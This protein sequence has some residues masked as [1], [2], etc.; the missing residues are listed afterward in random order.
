MSRSIYRSRRGEAAIRALYDAA[1]ERLGLVHENRTVRTH[2]G[3]THVLAIGPADA[4]PVV[5]LPGG[6]FLGPTC[7]G[8]F[9]PLAAEHRLYAPDI[10]GQPG[11][12]APTRPSPRGDGHAR[13]L[14]AVLDGLGLERAALVGISYGAGIA[15]RLAGHA[16]ER[17][18]RA[19]LVSP[20][21]LVGGPLAPMLIEV[22]VPMLR[23]CLAPNRERLLRAARPLLS[24]PDE[25]LA[26]QIG[27][28]YRHVRLDPQLPRLTTVAELRDCAASFLVFAAA[29]DL[30]FP[31]AAVAARAREVIPNLAGV[32]VLAG[33]RHIPTRA[34]F[35]QI[36]DRLRA[37]LHDRGGAEGSVA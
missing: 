14:E 36:N 17:I 32:E 6:N 33:S 8:W 31:G 3:D 9:A 13:W 25:G 29:D 7:L 20:A 12:S 35:A 5:V 2:F 10:I 22:V 30:F 24:E 23:Y 4:P 18:S 21:G 26:T 34:A 19:A 27:A 37:F 28:V 16:P 11:R 1:L 15:L